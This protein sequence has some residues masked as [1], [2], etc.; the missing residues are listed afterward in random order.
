LEETFF[1]RVFS[2][3]SL[4]RWKRMAVHAQPPILC[5]K[6]GLVQQNLILD[7]CNVKKFYFR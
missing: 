5:G 3:Q 4:T 2:I 6:Q 1:N 7:C